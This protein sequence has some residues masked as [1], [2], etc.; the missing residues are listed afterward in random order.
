MKDRVAEISPRGLQLAQA[1]RY[2]GIGATKFGQMVADGRM[3]KARRIDG[4][5]VWDCRELDDAFDALPHDEEQD[6]GENPW[7]SVTA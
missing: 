7:D 4:R 3:P 1:A 6:E 2:I 5:K